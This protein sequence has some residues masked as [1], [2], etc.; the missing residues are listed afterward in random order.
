MLRACRRAAERAVTVAVESTTEEASRLLER[1][2]SFA[3]FFDEMP[4]G[5]PDDGIDEALATG[6]RDAREQIALALD[7][8]A[9]KEAS[10]VSCHVDS[11]L[12]EAFAL[13]IECGARESHEAARDREESLLSVL[14]E[15]SLERD[16]LI[17]ER[18]RLEEARDRAIDD[19]RRDREDRSKTD[20]IREAALRAATRAK[21]RNHGVEVALA[22]A[23][24]KDE[25][26]SRHAAALEQALRH[27]SKRHARALE[28]ALDAKDAEHHQ[29][30]NDKKRQ[31]NDLADRVKRVIKSRPLQSAL[32]PR[33][34]RQSEQNDVALRRAVEAVDRICSDINLSDDNGNT[35]HDNDS[36]YSGLSSSSTPSPP[37]ARLLGR[38]KTKLRGDKQQHLQ[39]RDYLSVLKGGGG[40]TKN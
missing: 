31:D 6:L 1:P 13:G 4:S 21:D 33:R 8:F 24:A 11:L 10:D 38:Q 7:I 23:R 15:V 19:A 32:P 18:H 27:Q 30:L 12:E 28:K 2:R 22:E 39:Q 16:A 25:A 20:E 40:R 5:L 29:A 9:A 26:F 17:G 3:L 35:R 36:Y 37:A 14:R 34:R